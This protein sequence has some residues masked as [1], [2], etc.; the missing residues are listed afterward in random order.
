MIALPHQ[1]VAPPL[2][3]VLV[4]ALVREAPTTVELGRA[5]DALFLLSVCVVPPFVVFIGDGGQ[6]RF[7]LY[8]N[9]DSP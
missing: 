3:D 1:A 6:A 9:D 5:A 8:E 4:R 2:R 7:R